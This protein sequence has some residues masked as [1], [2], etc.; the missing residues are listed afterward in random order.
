MAQLLGKYKPEYRE[1]A[2]RICDF[3]VSQMDAEG[4]IGKSWAEDD[5]TPLVRDGTSGSFLTLALCEAARC[6][7]GKAV[8]RG[9]DP[10]LRLL[11]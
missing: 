8:S 9:G 3:A 7:G 2:L 6:T 10:Q 11:L 5:L 4:K 1:A